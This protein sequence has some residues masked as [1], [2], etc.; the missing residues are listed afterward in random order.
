MNVKQ[1]GRRVI[2]FVRDIKWVWSDLADVLIDLGES[3]FVDWKDAQF[4]EQFHT[5]LS[6]IT[7]FKRY[8]DMVT[9]LFA[10]KKSS[11]SSTSSSTPSNNSHPEQFDDEAITSL[12]K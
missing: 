5:D 7:N 2:T 1:F 11:L 3:P 6:K 9:G 8:K 4:N 10:W 12:R